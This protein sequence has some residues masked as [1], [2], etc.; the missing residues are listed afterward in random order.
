MHF[1]VFLVKIII[2][3]LFKGSIK[4]IIGLFLLLH[5]SSCG[6][7]DPPESNASSNNEFTVLCCPIATPNAFLILD[8][9]PNFT[10][11]FRLAF[12][13][14]QLREDNVN[15]IGFSTNMK[16]LVWIG[17]NFG[18]GTVSPESVVTNAITTTTHPINSESIA[19]INITTWVDTYMYNGQ[20]WGTIDDAGS[21]NFPSTASFGTNTIHS[22]TVDLVA[23]NGT[24][25]CDYTYVDNN[26]ITISG[27]FDGSFKIINEF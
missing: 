6:N 21:S 17:T 7:D 4:L 8:D 11:A 23:R 16:Q 14:G 13:D 9:G 18:S 22:F 12:T 1:Y 24:I 27:H 20:Q 3:N 25:D 26:N 15:G 5:L 2:M 10:N 19:Q